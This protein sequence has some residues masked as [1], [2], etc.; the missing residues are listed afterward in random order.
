MRW[1][2]ISMTKILRLCGNI[3]YG[4]ASQSL[5]ALEPGVENESLEQLF[6]SQPDLSGLECIAFD[7]PDFDSGD[8]ELLSLLDHLNLTQA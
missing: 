6:L 7:V 8:E 2:H 1:G 3:A 4:E 5:Q